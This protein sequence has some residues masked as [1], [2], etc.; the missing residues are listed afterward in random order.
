M[1][2]HPLRA[3]GAVSWI[4]AGLKRPA[5]VLTTALKSCRRT[6]GRHV[7]IGKAPPPFGRPPGLSAQR[8]RRALT[9]ANIASAADLRNAY[10]GNLLA[11]VQA[12]CAPIAGAEPL[13]WRC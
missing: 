13:Q 8:A 6:R 9:L 7:E 12:F 10:L 1:S 11:G 5:C 3:L 2:E 4:G